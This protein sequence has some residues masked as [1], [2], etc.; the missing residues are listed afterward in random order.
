MGWMKAGVLAIILS[1]LM[2][3]ADSVEA[4]GYRWIL[5]IAKDWAVEQDGGAPVLHLL[6]ARP[7][8]H[9]RRPT[10][11]ALADTPAFQSVTLEADV[12]RIGGSLLLVY[13]Y[14]DENHFNYAHLSNDP[15][16][17]QPVHNGIF[18]VYGGDR[19]RISSTQGPGSLPS[20]AEW[21][22]VKL[23]YD[24]STGV[25]DV[26]VNGEANP[27]L[28]AVDLSLGAGRVGIGSFFDTAMFRNVKVTGK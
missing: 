4:F 11:F 26:L 27:S 21:Y 5:P 7:S 8:E 19:V 23:S 18:H 17:K 14:K 24:G 20:A 1:G 22:R 13:A 3:A 2:M 12:R 16:S 25:V 6:V 9:P 28:H 15:P 10:Q